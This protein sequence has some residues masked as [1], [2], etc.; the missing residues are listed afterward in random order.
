MLIAEADFTPKSWGFNSPY[1][2]PCAVRHG[3]SVASCVSR[4][5]SALME[6]IPEMASGS[7]PHSRIYQ[8]PAPPPPEYT[9]PP[10]G[11]GGPPR[12]KDPG[13]DAPGEPAILKQRRGFVLKQTVGDFDHHIVGFVRTRVCQQEVMQ[14]Q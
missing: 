14:T 9:P 8:P 2:R 1:C 13:I 6:T 4:I 3:S 12:R 11:A 7:I 5:P 10:A